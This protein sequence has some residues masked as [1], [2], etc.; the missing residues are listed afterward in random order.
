MNPLSRLIAF[1]VILLILTLTGY[2]LYRN[3]LVLLP[4][5]PPVKTLFSVGYVLCWLFFFAGLFLE[6]MLPPALGETLSFIGYT[7]LLV[8]MYLLLTF[9]ATDILLWVVK[10]LH[11]ASVNLPEI[12]RS[13][14]LIAL[15]GVCVIMVIGNIRFRHP[16]VE[17]LDLTVNKPLENK[18]LTILFASDIHLGNS[19]GKRS[20]QRYVQLINDRKPD[21]I[22]LGGDITDRTIGPLLEQKLHEELKQLNAPLGVY[23]ILGNHEHYSGHPDSLARYLEDAG[24]HVLRDQV[25]LIDTSLYIIGREDRIAGHRLPLWQLMEE[26]DPNIPTIV[27]DHQPLKLEEASNLNVD[28]QLSGHTHNGQIFPGNLIVKRMFE[29]PYGYLLKEHTHIYVSSG[30]GI[31]GPLFRIGTQSELVTI[32]LH[33]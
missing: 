29:N 17:H 22:L 23:A 1:L 18:K 13:I 20:L 30:L 4:A 3:L 27:L 7:F 2:Y 26:L 16:S 33:Y 12:K 21:L 5:K 6:H 31:W 24:I 14:K 28:L 15:V 9:A 19:I 10:Q 8:A 25:A 32:R 11:L